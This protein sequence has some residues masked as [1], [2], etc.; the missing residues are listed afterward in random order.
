MDSPSDGVQHAVGGQD[1]QVLANLQQVRVADAVGGHECLGADAVLGGQHAHRFAFFHGVRDWLGWLG[2]GD[3][4][5]EHIV[6]RLIAGGVSGRIGGGRRGG[7]GRGQRRIQREHG[8][9]RGGVDDRRVDRQTAVPG[10]RNE[11]HR[12]QCRDPDNGGDAMEQVARA[13]AGEAIERGE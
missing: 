9:R 7:V 10:V 3:A 12:R 4:R 5:L 2:R 11:G 1:G 6:D 13:I 8:R